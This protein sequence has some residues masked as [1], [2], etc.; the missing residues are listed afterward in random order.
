MTNT[1]PTME[2][3]ITNA[4]LQHEVLTAKERKSRQ[5]DDIPDKV[6]DHY[7]LI[8]TLEIHFR[9]AGFIH[10]SE[11]LSDEAVE[12]AAKANLEDVFV[13]G[14]DEEGRAYVASSSESVAEAVLMIEEAKFELM[15]TIAPLHEEPRND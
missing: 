15:R 9:K 10:R 4:L 14:R 1:T 12:R 5:S 11:V 2:E 6:R 13:L 7:N 8:G 3:V